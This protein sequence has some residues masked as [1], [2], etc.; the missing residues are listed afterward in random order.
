L[1]GEIEHGDSIGG[2]G[3]IGENDVQWMTAG[4]GIIHEEYH[5]K[6]FARTGGTLEMC[7][8]W[9]NLPAKDKRTPPKYQAIL[10][11]EIPQVPLPGD[12]GWVR[13]IAGTFNGTQ[14]KVRRLGGHTDV[15]ARDV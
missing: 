13:V 12:A 8:I 6:Q 10:K 4:D 14:G 3:V 1:Q 9:V 7:Q 5:S 2:T 15:C 11:E